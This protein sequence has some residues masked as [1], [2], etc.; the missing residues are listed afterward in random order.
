MYR[1]MLALIYAHLFIYSGNVQLKATKSN[2]LS[3]DLF[4]FDSCL[5]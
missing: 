1:I 2:V 5:A 3:V 4:T